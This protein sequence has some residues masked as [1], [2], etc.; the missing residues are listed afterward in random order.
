MM[1]IALK[2]DFVANIAT[3]IAQIARLITDRKSLIDK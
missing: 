2:I 1:I 3:N